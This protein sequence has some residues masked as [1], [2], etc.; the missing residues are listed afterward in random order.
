MGTSNLA[1]TR[2]WRS[3]TSKTHWY[4]CKIISFSRPP[5]FHRLHVQIAGRELQANSLACLSC[6]FSEG[7]HSCRESLCLRV[8]LQ[9]VR[10]IMPGVLDDEIQKGY[11]CRTYFYAICSF[12]ELEPSTL[13]AICNNLDPEPFLLHAMHSKLGPSISHTICSIL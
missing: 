2:I 13:H 9:S 11:S 3:Q 12:W 4:A 10:R 6:S 1:K 8:S 5:H 7:C